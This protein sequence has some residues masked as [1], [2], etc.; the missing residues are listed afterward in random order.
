M[1]NAGVGVNKRYFQI[2]IWHWIG[3]LH[4]HFSWGAGGGGSKKNFL[5]CHFGLG[6]L[7][8][9]VFFW[10]GGGGGGYEK[11]LLTYS[12]SQNDWFDGHCRRLYF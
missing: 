11:I 8:V 9:C 3:Q 5:N 7:V 10:G 2:T 4:G 6:C 12:I 1:T